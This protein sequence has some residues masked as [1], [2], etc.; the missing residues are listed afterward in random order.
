MESIY[1][2]CNEHGAGLAFVGWLFAAAGLTFLSCHSCEA[3]NNTGTVKQQTTICCFDS[4]SNSS[5]EQGFE[6]AQLLCAA[7][8]I[9]VVHSRP[10][11]SWSCSTRFCSS[12]HQRA[13]A[14]H[15]SKV[16]FASR[17]GAVINACCCIALDEA[18]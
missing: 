10:M 18:S 2:Q 11:S 14:E 12:N 1:C 8:I 3:T 7:G 6:A 4:S 13:A 15:C 17:R 9:W 5:Y 16:N